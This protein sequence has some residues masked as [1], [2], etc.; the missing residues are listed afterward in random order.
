MGAFGTEGGAT[1]IT[2]LGDAPSTAARLSSTVAA[3]EIIISEGAF[4]AVGLDGADL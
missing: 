3:G 1:D 4:L 2:V